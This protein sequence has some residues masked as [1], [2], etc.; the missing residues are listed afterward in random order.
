M[1]SLRSR[2]A[3]P[4]RSRRDPYT[5]FAGKDASGN[6]P[7]AAG[8]HFEPS[9]FLPIFLLTSIAGLRKA[10]LPQI[11]NLTSQVLCVFT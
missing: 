9:L 4:E 11:R 6:S 3:C 8:F 5:F 1:K 2:K 10:F 7:G